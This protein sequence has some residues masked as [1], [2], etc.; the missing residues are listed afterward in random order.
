MYL[1]LEAVV[2]GGKFDR[3]VRVESFERRENS[4]SLRGDLTFLTEE[5]VWRDWPH[6]HLWTLGSPHFVGRLPIRT[7]VCVIPAAKF[8]TCCD[9]PWDQ[10]DCGNHIW[11]RAHGGNRCKNCGG[12][13]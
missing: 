9:G 8:N 6:G 3:V 11:C 2:R 7:D 12:Q 1:A 4:M 5:I 13:P 10:C